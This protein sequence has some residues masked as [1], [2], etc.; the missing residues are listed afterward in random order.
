[1]ATK[2]LRAAQASA[3]K[4]LRLADLIAY[5]AYESGE[6]ETAAQ[7]AA[8]IEA[9]IAYWVRAKLALRAGKVALFERETRRAIRGFSAQGEQSEAL[10]ESCVS[11]RTSM[12]A[13]YHLANHAPLK[14]LQYLDLN[15]DDARYVA[16]DHLSKSQLRRFVESK[17]AT[18]RMANNLTS[19]LAQDRALLKPVLL[20]RELRDD[21]L[22]AAQQL[23]PSGAAASYIQLRL[24]A[25][26]LQGVAKAEALFQAAHVLRHQADG[27]F[28]GTSIYRALY[29]LEAL[30]QSKEARYAA[31]ALAEQA[32]NLLPKRSQAY[33]AVLCAASYWAA[34]RNKP[35]ARAIYL[36]YAKNGAYQAWAKRFGTAACPSPDF[37]KAQFDLD[38]AP[39]PALLRE[40][41]AHWR[42][43]RTQL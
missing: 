35:L 22:L 4:R 24:R 40:W 17:I 19:Q 13:S 27:D 12:L 26:K 11:S 32:A 7:F 39:A 9:P 28:Y 33:A 2:L 15:T 30:P 20:A 36:R 29:S 41:K 43:L 1:M 3:L 14:A 18:Q 21:N 42:E 8:L 34:P 31:V 23:E 38:A 6:F 5:L 16:E 37:A 10:R 25:A